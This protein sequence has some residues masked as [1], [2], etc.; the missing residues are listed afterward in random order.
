MSAISLRT[1]SSPESITYIL[2]ILLVQQIVTSLIAPR[3]NEVFCYLHQS[4]R[5][6]GI[7]ATL[8]DLGHKAVRVEW[9]IRMRT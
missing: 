3:R 4:S 9:V 8:L 6:L 5:S 2:L 7:K 1:P